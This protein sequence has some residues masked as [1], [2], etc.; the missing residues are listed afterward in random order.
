LRDGDHAIRFARR[1]YDVVGIDTS[2]GQLAVARQKA[3]EAGFR[4][5]LVHGNMGAFEFDKPFDAM[6]CLFGGFG[7]LLKTRDV[8]ECLRCVRRHLAPDGVFAFEFCQSSGVQPPPDR[9]WLHRT[10]NR[11]ELFRLVESPLRP[12]DPPSAD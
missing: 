10:G 3:G 11:I 2:R 12:E 4:I 5:R 6:L 1:G 7:Y 9:S 8:L